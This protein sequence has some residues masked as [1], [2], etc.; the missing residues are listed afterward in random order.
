MNS[1]LKINL[2]L[3]VMGLAVWGQ[4]CRTTSRSKTSEAPTVSKSTSLTEE[5]CRAA[6]SNTAPASEQS[7]NGYGIFAATVQNVPAYLGYLK[8][9]RELL[10]PHG[11]RAVMW[12]P[13]VLN[14][15]EGHAFGH[16][17]MILEFPSMKNFDSFYCSSDYQGKVLGERL[18]ATK[19][20]LSVAKEGDVSSRGVDS[21][22]KADAVKGFIL[23]NDV[24]KDQA[25]YARYLEAAT[26]LAKASGGQRLVSGSMH[27]MIEGR[28]ED[29]PDNL[30]LFSF[31]SMEKLREWYDS[32]AYKELKKAR[33][34]ASEVKFVVAK[35]GL[36]P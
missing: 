15:L 16:F 7:P 17:F 28:A 26:E 34:K 30:T 12:G 18:S 11:G 13:N 27:A 2:I 21:S 3:A 4:G 6:S 22:S 25:A 32:P 20:V 9:A 31:P 8:K 36:E 24:V 35:K 23:F 5:N 33:L 14:L 10:P 29:R 19:V 1:K